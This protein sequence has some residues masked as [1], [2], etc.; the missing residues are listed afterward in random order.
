MASLWKKGFTLIELLIVIAIIGIITAITIPQLSGVEQ[1]QVAR[2]HIEMIESLFFEARAKTISS[3][4]LSSYGIALNTESIALFQ[5]ESY[6][7]ENI[8]EEFIF[9]SGFT[10]SSIDL[11]S[12]DD[13]SF[14][15][16]SGAVTN[17]GQFTLSSSDG[18]IEYIFT[19][20][21]TGLLE[22]SP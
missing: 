3:Q 1:R 21:P 9:E 10:L 7:E 4:E 5:G 18:T 2:F 20:T 6:D 12:G 17:P 15:R 13:F 8:V 19:V 11:D 22:R 16:L 14:T